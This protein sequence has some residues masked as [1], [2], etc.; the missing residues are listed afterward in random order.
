MSLKLALIA[1]LG[2]M[3]ALAATAGW[4]QGA[5]RTL[6]EAAPSGYLSFVRENTMSLDG[7]QVRL[8]PGG[9]IRGVNNLLLTPMS[10]PANSLVK[11]ELDGSGQ[12]SRAWILSREEAA[13]ANA[14]GGKAPSWA[15]SPE[16]GRSLEQITGQG[17]QST[18]GLRPGEQPRDTGPQ[19]VPGQSNNP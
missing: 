11:Y 16:T 1:L 8:A 12:I 3:V 4:A 17:R 18:I 9:Q 14:S 5:L 10:V 15:T 13:R 6:P 7:R 2:A 19:P